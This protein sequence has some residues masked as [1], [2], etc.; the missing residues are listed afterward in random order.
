MHGAKRAI[1]ASIKRC[2]ATVRKGSH[3][4]LFCACSSGKVKGSVIGIDL[5]TTNSGVWAVM[6]G[7]TPRVIENS[8]G[9]RTTPS[10][11]AFTKEGELLVGLHGPGTAGGGRGEEP[12]RHQ[13]QE[14]VFDV[15]RLIG[16]RFDDPEVREDAKRYPFKVVAGP[17]D[18]PLVE[19]EYMETIRRYSRPRRCRRP[20]GRRGK[21][22]A[23][24]YLGHP[25]TKAVVTVPAYFNDAQRQATKEAGAIAGLDVLRIIN[26]PTAAALAY[27]LEKPAST[28]WSSTWAAA[29]STF[30]SSSN[31][32]GYVSEVK[33][34]RTA[35]RSS[36]AMTS[37]NAHSAM[38]R[39]GIQGTLQGVD[40]SG[41]RMALQRIRR[42]PKRRRSSCR[43]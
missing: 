32:R 25:V 37:I 38:G 39:R 19:V 29:L 36:A 41:D 23:E 18:E 14:T 31:R 12:V 17:N 40:L 2:N 8:E 27:G 7:K 15:K 21:K 35:I 6:E 20:P 3:S 22:T 16:R 26:E 4:L 11:V 43:R 1:N 5:G 30:P 9:A 10:V 28:C 33:S 34:R 42:P 24:Q 13:P